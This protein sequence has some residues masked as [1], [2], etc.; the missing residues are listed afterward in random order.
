[1]QVP[2]RSSWPSASRLFSRASSAA[3]NN[4]GGQAAPEF[5]FEQGPSD[6]TY[7]DRTPG[8]PREPGIRLVASGQAP[9]RRSRREELTISRTE[10]PSLTIATNPSQRV[11]VSG[12][13]REDWLLRFCAYGD[14][15]SEREALDRLQEVSFARLG[16]TISLNAPGVPGVPGAG[17]NLGVHAPADAPITV[18]SSLAPVVVRNM[19]GPVRVTAIHA[20]AKILNTTGKVDAAAFFVDFAGSEGTV[21]LSAEAEI[22]LKLTSLKF[23]GTLIAWAQLPVRVLVPPGFQTPFQAI[24]SRPQDFVC[25]TEFGTSIKCE[26]NGELYVF[27]YPGDGSSPPEDVHLRSEHAAVIV[28]AGQ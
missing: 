24:V 15:D 6:L 22:N 1:M 16:A 5:L 8:Q 26:R 2:R 9:Y 7:G 23:T 13:R 3:R 28:D 10:I 17:G 4:Q 21:I 19:T 11:E 14:G 20:R 25:R 18:H 12:H 27:T